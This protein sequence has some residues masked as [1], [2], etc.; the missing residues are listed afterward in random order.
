[1]NANRFGF[2]KQT[3]RGMTFHIWAIIFNVLIKILIIFFL[4]KSG[5]RVSA[6]NAIF[7]IGFLGITWLKMATQQK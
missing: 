2:K 4:K 5:K 3:Q 6:K 1:L 7:K